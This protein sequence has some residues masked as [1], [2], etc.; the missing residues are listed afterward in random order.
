MI[1]RNQPSSVL[2]IPSD[3]T[4]FSPF[5]PPSSSTSPTLPVAVKIL[6]QS[7]P[8]AH[9]A[10]SLASKASKAGS[11]KED[12]AEQPTRIVQAACARHHTLLVSNCGRVWACGS[13]PDGRLGV[14][15]KGKGEEVVAEFVRVSGPWEKD[16]GKVVQ[17]SPRWRR[18]VLATICRSLIP[19]RSLSTFALKVS[20]GLTF[21]L[22]L[23]DN[24]KVYATGSHE[25]GQCGNGVTGA[26]ISGPGKTSFDYDD[27]P[28]LLRPFT[29]NKI[30][31]IASGNQHSMAMDEEGMVYTWGFAGYGRLGLNDQVDKKVPTM[32]PQ[33]ARNPN[34]R[35]R[36]IV[37]GPTCSIVIDKQGIYQIAGKWKLTG[38]GSSGSPYTY[39]KSV[40]DIVSC[41]TIKAAS[42][43]N[44]HFLT[45][46][47]E[48]G[49]VTSVGFGQNCIGEL[50]LGDDEPKNST[51]PAEIKPLQGVDVID[52]A[53]GGSTTYWV[54][55]P[56]EAV[57]ALK[58]W[59]E[60]VDSPDDC[61]V[62]GK[63]TDDDLIECEKCETPC[64][65]KCND[66]P[67]DAV[68]EG[69]WLCSTCTAQQ[70]D[71]TY[72]PVPSKTPAAA[73]PAKAGSKRKAPAE[74]VVAKKG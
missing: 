38:D 50:G 39:F 61:M 8:G 69:E 29:K 65:L 9:T 40:Q 7:L 64:H 15:V 34:T 71:P 60:E 62:C 41:K 42:G 72:Q 12:T 35:A 4:P 17:V 36:D 19:L 1:G 27:Y 56:G 20:A 66:P 49:G 45:I 74:P 6:A 5:L 55:K 28:V 59:P 25:N 22:F 30:V 46:P 23:I 63:D 58:R 47:S 57:E 70:E 31:G 67:L 52:L 68:P 10:K 21:S 51:R 44:G 2:G 18:A 32:V 16:G 3:T 54:V 26:R 43:G 11:S 24:G 33:Y 53:A 37:C 48:S 14:D 73:N 13:N